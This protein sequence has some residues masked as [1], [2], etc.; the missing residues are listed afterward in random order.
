M[1]CVML[2]ITTPLKP[3]KRTFNLVTYVMEKNKIV[4][5]WE[6]HPIAK[7][8]EFFSLFNLSSLHLPLI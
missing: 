2:I 7:D 4:H 5:K 8:S 3:T 6:N 1:D